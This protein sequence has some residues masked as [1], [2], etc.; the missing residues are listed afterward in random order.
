MRKL[1]PWKCSWRTKSRK[2]QNWR[3]IYSYARAIITH[4]SVCALSLFSLIFR[5][6]T[7]MKFKRDASHMTIG[8]ICFGFIFE[9]PDVLQT[10]VYDDHCNH[11]CHVTALVQ[12]ERSNY[13]RNISFF[14]RNQWH[15]ISSVNQYLGVSN[16]RWW[17]HSLGHG[18]DQPW[19]PLQHYFRSLHS[20]S[21]WILSV[22]IKI[23]DLHHG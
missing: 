4:L 12:L 1:N 16:I 22:S 6:M 2:W 15:S 3:M 10:I 8:C 7:W 19:R 21:S 20:S 18:S 11:L 23:Q 5:H 9:S 17:S 13:P 14:S